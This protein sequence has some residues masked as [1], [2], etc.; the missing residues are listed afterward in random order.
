MPQRGAKRQ[1]LGTVTHNAGRRSR[2]QAQAGERSH[3]RARALTALQDALG[4]P[5]RRSG[6][7]VSTS[8]TF[9]EPR[10]SDRW[11][12]WRTASRSAP[13]TGA[14][15]SA[16]GG[17]GRL[18]RDGGGAHPPVPPLPPGARRRRPQGQA[19]RI[20]AQ[21]PDRRRREGAARRSRTC[22]LEELGLEEISVASL[23]KRFEE[24]YV[25]GQPD[26]LRA[27]DLEAL[28]LLQ[29]VRDEAH[30]FAI[31]YHR[32]LRQ[33]KMTKSALDEVPGLGPASPAAAQGVRLGQEAAGTQPRRAARGAV[34]PGAGR[35]IAI[36]AAAR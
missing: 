18:R 12:S 31:T 26:P 29:Q 4:L 7:S 30:R 8:R 16:A 14:S 23:A 24:V 10:S 15:R 9:R 20:P 33:K 32:Q 17:P 13:T 34:A 22:V 35:P 19:L 36:R 2:L 1:L 27:R 5:R 11:S 25:P 21:P 6:S 28:H 3:A